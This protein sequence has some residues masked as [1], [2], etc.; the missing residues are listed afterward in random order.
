[1]TTTTLNNAVTIGGG[2]VGPTGAV[3]TTLQLT[4]TAYTVAVALTNGAIEGNP[5]HRLRFYAATSPLSLTTAQAVEQLKQVAAY[6]DVVPHR[7]PGQT[8][9]QDFPLLA[10]KGDYLYT[11]Y[12]D[13]TMP[14]G[15][16]RTM[17]ST[18]YELN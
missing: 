13:I 17:T 12:E 4:T 1:M 16:T 5:N 2:T 11:W 18:L 10:R 9:V 3:K 7:A 15:L 8:T 14:A 6:V